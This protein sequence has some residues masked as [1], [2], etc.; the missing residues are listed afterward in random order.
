MEDEQKRVK[1]EKDYKITRLVWRY[2]VITVLLKNTLDKLSSSECKSLLFF[3]NEE[4]VEKIGWLY[5][6]D[7]P[8]AEEYLLGRRID[9]AIEKDLEKESADKGCQS[10]DL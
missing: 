10:F 9:K 2:L 3:R 5:K 4:S 1:D 7:K 6:P 8:D